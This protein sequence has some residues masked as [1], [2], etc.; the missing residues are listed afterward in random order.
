MGSNGS[1][2]DDIVLT[3]ADF[4]DAWAAHERDAARL[5]LAARRLEASGEWAHDG[6]VSMTAWLRHHCRMSNR[7]AAALVHRGRFLDQFPAIAQAACDRVLSAGQVNALRTVTRPAVEPVMAEQQGQIVAII[8]PLT[9]AD[10]EQAGA[11]WRQR[12]EAIAQLPE[13]V[14]PERQLRFA[15]TADG[16]VGRFVLDDN[17]AVQFE[18]AIRTASTWDGKTDTRDHSRRTA[19]ALVDVCAYFNANHTR[20]ATPRRRPHVELIVEADTL[21]STPLAWT[22]D[23][24]FIGAATTDML[25]CDCVIHRV[26]R[27]GDTILNYGR[28]TYTVP[29]DL[30]RAVAARDGGC[31]F[32]GCDRSVSWC[33]AHHI[34]YWRHLGL[35]DL[36]NLVLLC[37][38][39]HHLVHRQKLHV[40]LLPNSDLDITFPDGTTRTSQPRHPP[41]TRGP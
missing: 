32:P 33:D 35:T 20:A 38:R 10:A 36:E 6:S 7:D 37:N 4:I 31:R 30:F 19:D 23:H 15:R 12:A 29:K 13:P 25:L 18:Q 21:A 16:L 9:V 22:T 2:L 24:A 3:G 5:A 1:V 26:L 11:L 8:A 34:H 40:K 41:G 14:D 28:A 17:G 39:H 27:A